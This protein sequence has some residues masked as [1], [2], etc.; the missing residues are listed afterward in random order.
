MNAFRWA[1][2]QAAHVRLCGKPFDSAAS[3]KAWAAEV[4]ACATERWG[5]LCI[6]STFLVIYKWVHRPV[7]WVAIFPFAVLFPAFE[8][9]PCVQLYGSNR[10]SWMTS[11]RQGG[12]YPCD[13]LLLSL[14][15]C[16]NLCKR[17][18]PLQKIYSSTSAELVG[19]VGRTL[20]WN[21]CRSRRPE[22]FFVPLIDSSSLYIPFTFTWKRL[23][24]IGCTG[25]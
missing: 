18:F 5:T 12:M 8:P 3:P 13:V 4:L 23:A 24:V 15:I 21:H 1:L 22:A 19:L 25:G 7:I 2:L 16:F 6:D 9:L 14:L 17:N 10:G 20:R 11:W